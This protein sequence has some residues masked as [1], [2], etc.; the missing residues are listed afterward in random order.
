MDKTSFGQKL[1][2]EYYGA[3]MRTR[4][5]RGALASFYGEDS[6]MVYNGTECNGLKAINHHI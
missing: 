5:E 1:C 6:Q 4:E 2:S 3:L